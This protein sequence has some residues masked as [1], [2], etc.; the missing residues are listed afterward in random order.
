MARLKQYLVLLAV[1]ITLPAVALAQ[2]AD[3]ATVIGTITDSQGGV[4]PGAAITAHNVDT[5]FARAVVSEANGFYRL[6]A[7]PLVV[8]SSRRSCRAWRK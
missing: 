6:S 4:L 1:V 3:T 8:T 2:S 5:G 7:L